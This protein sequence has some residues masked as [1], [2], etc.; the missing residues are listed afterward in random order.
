MVWYILFYDA[1]DYFLVP[2]TPHFN[3]GRRAATIQIGAHR[4]W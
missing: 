4:E 3:C 2:N 1:T